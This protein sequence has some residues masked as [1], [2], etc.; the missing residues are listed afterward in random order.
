[1]RI[2][3]IS[4]VIILLIIAGCK[5]AEQKSLVRDNTVNIR[6]QPA[7]IIEYKIP[8]RVTGVL[9]T[10]TQMKLSFK[11][12][13][14][15]KQLNIREGESVRRGEVLAVLDLSEVR[16]QVNQARIGL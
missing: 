3:S 14:I 13:G 4:F 16:A 7:E 11:T 6:I 1:M 10:T 15:I 9:G 12:G 8:V 5:P 2:R